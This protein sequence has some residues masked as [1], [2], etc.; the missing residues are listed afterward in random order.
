M[1]E[2]ANAQ[3]VPPPQTTRRFLV[4]TFN[5]AWQLFLGVFAPII[6]GAIVSLLLI[7]AAGPVFG[8]GWAV[9]LFVAVGFQREKRR[10]RSMLVLSHVEQAMRLNLP[11]AGTLRLWGAI[12]SPAVR[13]ELNRLA[14]R[15]EDGGSLLASIEHS[16]RFLPSRAVDQ[17]ES[18]DRNGQ[19]LSAIASILESD[20]YRRRRDPTHWP[21]IKAYAFLLAIV[22]PAIV[23]IIMIFVIPKF[24]SILRS[25]KMPLP[26]A[27]EIL[28]SSASSTW[29]APFSAIAII[30]FFAAC[31]SA[32]REIISGRR[33]RVSSVFRAPLDFILWY[34][35]VI[36]ALERD[37]GM[38][39]VCATVA[40]AVGASRELPRALFEA[41]QPHLNRVLADRVHR[42][43]E[44]V[45]EGRPLA[46]AARDARLPTLLCGLLGNDRSAT[47]LL[48]T[49]RFLQRYYD[50]RFSRLIILVREAALPVFTLIAAGVVCLVALS[51]FEPL[52][53]LVEAT[54]RW[55]K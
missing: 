41:E 49:L 29:L 3:H 18:A 10:R 32:M 7:P 22:I 23:T 4:R 9:M 34:L 21:F 6:A 45:A 46:D 51:V 36:G 40:D 1:I 52:I 14:G 42:W 24:E 54:V 17:L 38:A 28:V 8:I 31:A 25:F 20:R 16:V 30:A 27:T 50:T 19:P 53:S 5:A 55:R 33:W 12:E 37:R 39:D 47:N 35:P 2:Y 44:Q 15:L 43:A 48:A 26:P 11:L 13:I